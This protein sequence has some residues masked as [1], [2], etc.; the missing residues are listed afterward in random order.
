MNQSNRDVASIFQ[1]AGKKKLECPL[2]HK[3]FFGEYKIWDHAKNIHKDALGDLASSEAEERAKKEFIQDAHRA[4]V[5]PCT[6]HCE[7]FIW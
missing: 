2:C 6:Y 5:V 4:Y 3:P 1:N 7:I